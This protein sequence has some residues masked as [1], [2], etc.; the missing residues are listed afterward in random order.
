MSSTGSCFDRVLILM[1][2]ISLDHLQKMKEN[3]IFVFTLLPVNTRLQSLLSF[4]PAAMVAI[5]P[6]LLK[7]AVLHLKAH[8]A[9]PSP[10]SFATQ[11]LQQTLVP[12]FLIRL[13]TFRQSQH[14][15]MSPAFRQRC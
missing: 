5:V 8:S 14:H 13:P 6:K 10:F 2:P 15:R 9:R 1:G 3:V 11:A 12:K 7:F 4:C